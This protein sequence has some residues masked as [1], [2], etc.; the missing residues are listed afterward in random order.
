MKAISSHEQTINLPGLDTIIELDNANKAKKAFTKDDKNTQIQGF[1]CILI[2]KSFIPILFRPGKDSSLALDILSHYTE[3]TRRSKILAKS[4]WFL[5]L[6]GFLSQLIKS[7][8][9]KA[10]STSNATDGDFINAVKK[11][12]NSTINIVKASVFEFNISR[13]LKSIRR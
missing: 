7:S 4:A 3:I 9:D 1:S 11:Q 6:H 10:S 13:S 12:F 8:V 2:D 5:R